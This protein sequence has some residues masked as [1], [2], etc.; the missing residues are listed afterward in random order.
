MGDEEGLSIP[1]LSYH[2]YFQFFQFTR[3]HFTSDCLYLLCTA[4][5]VP[6]YV[7]WPYF[8]LYWSVSV[9]LFSVTHIHASLKCGKAKWLIFISLKEILYLRR[10]IHYHRRG[11]SCVIWE[12]N[13][14]LIIVIMFAAATQRYLCINPRQLSFLGSLAFKFYFWED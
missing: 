4:R 9:F 5:M 1:G 12:P 14:N 2:L 13:V 3:M 7:F 10:F 11:S 6:Q 8:P